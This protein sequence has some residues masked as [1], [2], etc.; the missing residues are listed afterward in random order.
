[1]EGVVIAAALAVAVS[2][3]LL[4]FKDTAFVTALYTRLLT[5]AR[6]IAWVSVPQ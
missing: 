3:G 4:V 6:I 5:A 1:M 2:V